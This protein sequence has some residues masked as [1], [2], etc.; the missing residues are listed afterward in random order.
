M[1]M[2]DF[3][4][5]LSTV[6]ITSRNIGEGN[7]LGDFALTGRFSVKLR[8]ASRQIVGKRPNPTLAGRIRSDE[9]YPNGV[10][11]CLWHV[12]H[13]LVPNWLAKIF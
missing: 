1:L 8:D 3:K 13:L 6:G 11:D 5:D 4:A 7:H 2:V 10:Q 12:L 9:V